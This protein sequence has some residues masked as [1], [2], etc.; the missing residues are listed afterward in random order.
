MLRLS[1]RFHPNAPVVALWFSLLPPRSSR[2]PRLN[3]LGFRD[4]SWSAL[5]R[6]SFLIIA[7]VNPGIRRRRDQQAILHLRRMVRK[8]CVRVIPVRRQG[9]LRFEPVGRAAFGPAIH[10]VIM[11]GQERNPG[12]GDSILIRGKTG[13]GT[14]AKDLKRHQYDK[15]P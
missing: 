3:A 15:K 13:E 1:W 4:L 14:R 7:A 9:T 5:D 6:F 8:R 12:A 10:V 2:S 11:P